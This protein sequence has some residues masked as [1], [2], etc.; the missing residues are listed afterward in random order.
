MAISRA[1]GR[2]QSK[3]RQYLL[4]IFLCPL[5]G[6]A[7]REQSYTWKLAGS[8]ISEPPNLDPARA[9]GHG[10]ESLRLKQRF[11]LVTPRVAALIR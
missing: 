2:V 1:I 6:S 10:Q 8:L 3:L 7:I 11:D 9:V 5:S 4:T